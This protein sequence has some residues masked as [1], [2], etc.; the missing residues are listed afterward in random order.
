MEI[1]H[2]SDEKF[3]EKTHDYRQDLKDEIMLALTTTSPDLSPLHRTVIFR[4]IENEL[5]RKIEVTDS[6]ISQSTKSD[7]GTKEL[8]DEEVAKFVREFVQ[9][10][11]EEL[12]KMI[13]I[14]MD[15]LKGMRL[16]TFL[17]YDGRLHGSLLR[18]IVKL[19]EEMRASSG[20]SSDEV[21]L[22]FWIRAIKRQQKKAKMSV[23]TLASKIVFYKFDESA[24]AYQRSMYKL[25]TRFLERLW[26]FTWASHRMMLAERLSKTNE[27]NFGVPTS[28][29]RGRAAFGR[30]MDRGGFRGRYRGKHGAHIPITEADQ[31]IAEGEIQGSEALEEISEWNKRFMKKMFKKKVPLWGVQSALSYLKENQE[32][33]DDS[34]EAT[35]Q[36]VE[37]YFRKHQLLNT[38]SENILTKTIARI[39]CE[40]VY[41]SE[42]KKRPKGYFTDFA[43]RFLNGCFTICAKSIFK[44]HK[45]TFKI[46]LLLNNIKDENAAKIAVNWGATM[47][48]QKKGECSEAVCTEFAKEWIRVYMPVINKA[49]EV[50]KTFM[51]SKERKNKMLLNYLKMHCADG[52]FSEEDCKKFLNECKERMKNLAESF[53]SINIER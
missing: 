3:D 52:E 41:F 12:I 38:Q 47:C 50:V 46:A 30:G 51:H 8:D 39:V 14:A 49:L 18:K 23:K 45:Q 16:Q 48:C 10:Q 15:S 34:F 11:K 35:Q 22:N 29:E 32:T 37:E 24:L 13:E 2:S 20:E 53:G 7:V 5:K 28:I 6:F 1:K 19:I 26:R 44:T 36:V 9:S 42:G 43:N 4:L 33:I 21:A 40:S 25:L 17:I 31:V 27:D